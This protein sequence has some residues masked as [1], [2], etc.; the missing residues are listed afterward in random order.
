M[1]DGSVCLGVEGVAARPWETPSEWEAGSIGARLLLHLRERTCHTD[2]C[3]NP[4]RAFCSA[5][6][7]SSSDIWVVETDPAYA[8]V[9]EEAQ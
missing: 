6:G 1:Q 9:Q 2:A 8:A 5:G 4:L 3:L 7:D